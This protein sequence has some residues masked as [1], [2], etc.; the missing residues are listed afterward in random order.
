M[1][2]KLYGSA[3]STAR[4]LVTIL[5]KQLPYELV[6]INIAKGDQKKWEYLKMQPYG[7]VPVMDDDGFVMFES[8]AI[9]RYLARKYTSGVKLIPDEGDFEGY[10]RFEQACSVEQSYFAA[11]A[12]T[13]GTELVIKRMQNLGEPDMAKVAQAE[14]LLDKVLSEYDAILVKQQYLTG[15]TICLADLFHLPNASALK[16]FGYGATF[17]KYPNANRW[18][19]NL[20]ERQAWT[21]ATG[22]ALGQ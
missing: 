11:A 14:A 2:I 19:K 13:I 5:E 20:Q 3:M 22:E 4:V 12:E 15:D 7:K 1:V 16:E 18:L 21:T 17:E 10:G 6:F 9:C 8:R